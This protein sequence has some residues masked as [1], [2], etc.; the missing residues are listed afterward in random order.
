MRNCLLKNT[1]TE[2]FPN[3]H[4]PGSVGATEIIFNECN[5][6]S[7]NQIPKTGRYIY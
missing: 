4:I 5:F 2:K 7:K 6:T 1:G 3:L